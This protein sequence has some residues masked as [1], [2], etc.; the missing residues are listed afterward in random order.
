MILF[1]FLFLLCLLQFHAVIFD[2]GGAFPLPLTIF[3]ITLWCCCCCGPRV[4]AGSFSC[5]FYSCFFVCRAPTDTH[6]QTR[7]RR[8]YKQQRFSLRVFIVLFFFF[9][10]CGSPFVLTR[11][12]VRCI[13]HISIFIRI[14]F[15]RWSCLVLALTSCCCCLCLPDADLFSWLLLLLLCSFLLVDRLSLLTNL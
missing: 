1:C 2:V 6:T 14:R 3:N 13:V 5:I 7:S 15:Y 12:C 10:C 8:V 4:L 11:F 9:T